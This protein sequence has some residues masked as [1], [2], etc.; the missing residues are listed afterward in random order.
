VPAGPAVRG[1]PSPARPRRAGLSP[2]S[3]RHTMPA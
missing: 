2:R 1:A 3:R